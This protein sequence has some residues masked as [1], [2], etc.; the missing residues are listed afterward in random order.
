[1]RKRQRRQTQKEIKGKRLRRR[2][3]VGAVKESQNGKQHKRQM[4]RSL[5]EGGKAGELGRN[6]GRHRGAKLRKN[7]K[8][9]L[10]ST[11]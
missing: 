2:R 11:F 6:S 7:F 10:F 8:L 1:M 9:S 5:K 3:R 4:G